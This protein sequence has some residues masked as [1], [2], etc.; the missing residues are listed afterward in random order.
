MRKYYLFLIKNEY[1]KVYRDNSYILYKMLESISNMQTYD[2]S[3]GISIFNQLCNK[4]SDKLLNNYIDSKIKHIKI[5]KKIIFI[6]SLFE[7]TYI[8]INK[9]CIIV[10][11][12]VVLPQIFKVFN[13]YNRQI[14]ICDFLNKNYFWLNKQIKKVSK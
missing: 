4:V 7:R 14:F 3:Y 12:N 10:K 11:T 5:N 1:Y 6:N 8:Q 9:S 13:I 2:Y